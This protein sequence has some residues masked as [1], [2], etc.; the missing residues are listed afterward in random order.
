MLVRPAV[1]LWA[2]GAAVYGFTL[3]LSAVDSVRWR[4]NLV[5]SVATLLSFIFLVIANVEVLED[6]KWLGNLSIFK[7]YDPVAAAVNGNNLASGAGVL[8]AIGAAGIALGFAGF[9]S[10]DLPAN[11]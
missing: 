10:R 4:P 9:L 7:A 5:G 1:S 11:S 2:L 6:W 8:S 3:Q